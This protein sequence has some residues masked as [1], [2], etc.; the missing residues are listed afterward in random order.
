MLLKSSLV[1]LA[2]F[3]AWFAAQPVPPA[4]TTVTLLTRQTTAIRAYSSAAGP[5]QRW[6]VT[7]DDFRPTVANGFPGDAP[8][9]FAQDY[10]A[11]DGWLDF[12]GVAVHIVGPLNLIANPVNRPRV[13]MRL[14]RDASG[15]SRNGATLDGVRMTG[16]A[17]ECLLRNEGME[18]AAYRSC[19]FEA[20]SATATGYVQGDGYA[21]II[22]NERM[23][24]ARDAVEP[25]VSATTS[26]HT[27]SDCTIL[28]GKLGGVLIRG[29]VTEVDFQ[30]CWFAGD[31]VSIVIED[32][33]DEPN[34][35]N[36]PMRV[37]LTNCTPES[38]KARR[39]VL[40]GVPRSE[41]VLAGWS[42]GM[43]VVED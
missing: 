38:E 24:G 31:G 5:T 2:A 27:F 16:P 30:N 25:R 22:T 20:G 28:A 21:V 23:A 12:D 11:G 6:K 35:W 17:R 13:L 19:F 36:Q 3:V 33:P 29:C 41:V 9:A 42:A 10:I 14:S 39:I 18:V 26:G 1:L 4:P 7:A 37:T 8:F 32:A 15:G 40:R 34:R 43:F